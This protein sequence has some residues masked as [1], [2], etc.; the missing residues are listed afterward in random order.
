MSLGLLRG[1]VLVICVL[2]IAG[3][4]VGTIAT[5]NNNGVVITF[6]LVTAIAVVVLIG[7]TMV[8]RAQSP[9]GID[10]VLAERIEQRVDELVAAGASE[11]EVRALVGDA[12]KLG[13]SA[14]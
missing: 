8:Q 2:G 5:D 10:E 14:R 4:I 6:G 9:V 7:T 12:V 13:K 3:M 1:M 11:P